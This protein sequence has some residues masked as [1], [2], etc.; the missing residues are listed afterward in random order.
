MSVHQPQDVQPR[1][2]PLMQHEPSHSKGSASS[3]VGSCSANKLL[4]LANE[5]EASGDFHRGHKLHQ[6]RIV[7]L[8]SAEVSCLMQQPG[9]ADAAMNTTV[10]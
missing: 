1:M 7:L 3:A 5:C 8:E 4:Q 6:R 2:S 9:T 10:I